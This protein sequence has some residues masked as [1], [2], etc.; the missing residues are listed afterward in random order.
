MSDIAISVNDLSKRYRIGSRE[1]Y[2]ALRDTLTDAIYAPFRLLE[3][4]ARSLIHGSGNH[5]HQALVPNTQDL[6]P[7][8][9]WAVKN[10]SFEIKRG[11]VV[12]IVGRNG[13]G[14][15]T[16]LKIL[17]RITKP[18]QGYAEI[19]GRVGS[20]LEVGTGF[21]PEL[22][23]RENVYLNG[24]ILGMKK[25][26]IKHKFDEI[27]S[28]AEVEKFI[29]T[30]VKHYSTG[31]HMRL[32][33]SVAAHLNP[34]ILLVDEVL[35][36]GDADFQRKC[37][38]K[39]QDV[40]GEGRT[41]IFV[42]HNTGAIVE[43]CSRVILLREGKL[44]EDGSGKEVVSNYLSGMQPTDGEFDLTDPSLRSRALPNSRF[45][46]TRAIVLNSEGRQGAQIKPRE[47]FGVVLQGTASEPIRDL[48]I[49]FAVQSGHGF[50][51]FNSCQR[52]SQLPCNYPA[53]Q[54]TFHV[55]FNPNLFGPGQYFFDIYASAPNA[56][57]HIRTAVQFSVLAVNKDLDECIRANFSGVILY[58]CTWSL[59]T[60][61]HD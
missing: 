20:L 12:G 34:E 31:M 32:A 60:D 19:Y 50:T 14:K 55:K 38:G 40:A 45:R 26:E 24:S 22:T 39:M 23:G 21:H 10:I 54:I 33:F 11:E 61:R 18:T 29:D 51:F 37:L 2:K 36:V 42:S 35:A 1:P 17:S 25:R 5:D 48:E 16:L 47:P 9:I 56:L 52:D 27:V 46:W 8:H 44:V 4:V 57:D 58:P 53:G 49:C 13:A 59:E 28:F 41:V 3:S 43:L 6:S 15:S 7:D 30:P